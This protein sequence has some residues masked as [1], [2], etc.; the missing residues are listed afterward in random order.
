MTFKAI[1]AYLQQAVNSDFFAGGVALGTIGIL[2]ALLRAVWFALEHVIAKRFFASVTIDSRSS[3]YRYFLLWLRQSGVLN[4]VR[5][6]SRI[7]PRHSRGTGQFSPAPGRYW[8]W[9]EKR[10]YSYS[11]YIDDRKRYLLAIVKI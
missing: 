2:A 10:F 4:N 8:F 9:F 3:S 7:N 5:Q 6:L 1:S 11:W